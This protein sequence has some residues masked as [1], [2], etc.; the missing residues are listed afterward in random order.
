MAGITL[1]GGFRRDLPAEV[2]A[3][4]PAFPGNV[5]RTPPDRQPP[6]VFLA[7]SEAGSY[8]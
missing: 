8:A 4:P 7:L 3:A 2:L 5:R 1:S 6:E